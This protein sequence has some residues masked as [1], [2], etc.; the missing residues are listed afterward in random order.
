MRVLLQHPHAPGEISGVVTYCEQL[1][2]A[3]RR[4]SVEVRVLSTYGISG[5]EIWRAVKETD[6]VH[7]NSHHLLLVLFARLQ[8][9]RV[10]LKYHY[11]YWD[12]VLMGPFMVRGFAGRFGEEW[13]F[14]RRL[15]RG[16]GAGGFK[17]MALRLARA[18][19]RVALAFAVH[20]RLAC[21]KFI[22]RSC[23]LPLDVVVDYPPM[24]FSGMTGLCVSAVPARARFVFVGRLEAHKGCDVLLRAAACLR[25]TADF[26]I[27]VIGEGPER[28][29]LERIVETEGL[30]LV[31]TFRGKLGGNAVLTEMAR[32][33]AVVVP[34]RVNEAF[35]LAALEAATVGRCVVGSRVGGIPELLEPDGLLFASGDH[36]GLAAHLRALIARPVEAEARGRELQRRLGALCDPVAAVRRAIVF[37]SAD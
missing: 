15:T 9:K 1:A 8:G 10:V 6:V 3:M 17:H 33:T 34:S 22:A 12:S 31:V 5:P 18:V 25:D 26:E 30:R 24:D 14:L 36:E 21:S 19:M 2:A 27:V 11:A 4:Q 29:A 35:S 20:R 28:A 37:Y 32:A 13:R 23:E 7:L 16:Q